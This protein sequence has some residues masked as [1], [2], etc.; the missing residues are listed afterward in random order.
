MSSKKAT[1]KATG[2]NTEQYYSEGNMTVDKRLIIETGEQKFSEYLSLVREFEIE[3]ENGHTDFVKFIDKIQHYNSSVD[4]EFIG[5]EKKL[6]RGGYQKDFNRVN[7]FKQRYFQLLT[8]GQLSNSTQKIHAFILAKICTLFI[9][10]INPAID[11]GC[12]QSQIKVMINELVINKIESIL[13]ERNIL[14]IYSD[15]ILA[16]VYF[17]TGNCHINWD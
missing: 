13:S 10:H 2:N 6:E 8:E 9:T 17:L 3:L 7:P 5:L 4:S 16:M 1:Q 15:D 11:S 12:S 14:N